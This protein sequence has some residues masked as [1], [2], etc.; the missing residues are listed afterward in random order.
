[1]LAGVHACAW[2]CAGAVMHAN[3]ELISKMSLQAPLRVHPVKF[4]GLSVKDKLKQIRKE[5]KGALV[6]L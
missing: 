1:M 6:Q 5:L 4:A 3:V 2:F